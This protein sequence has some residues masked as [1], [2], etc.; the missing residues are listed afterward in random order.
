MPKDTPLYE[1]TLLRHG[2]SE[3]N[4]GG[5]YQGQAE[6]FPLT[7]RGREQAW[8]LAVYW[9]ATGVTFDTCIAS[10]QPRARETAEI[11]ADILGLEV[12]LD[13]LWMERDNGNFAGLHHAEVEKKPRD[14]LHSIYTPIGETG[15][16]EWELHL[17]GGRAIQSIL[18]RAPARYLI[19][20]HGAILNATLRAALGIVPQSMFRGTWFRFRNTAFASLRYIPAS[21]RWD[22][23]GINRRPH[24]EAEQ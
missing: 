16:T 18:H 11:I 23:H 24:W 10:P 7:E 5:Y 14:D 20:S 17:R 1:I 21:D 19:V 4:A 22:V 12:E 6:G 13:P 3:G 15:E 9:Q 8:S 2:E